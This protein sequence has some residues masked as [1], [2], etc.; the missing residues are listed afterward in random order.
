[1]NML[2]RPDLVAAKLAGDPD[3]AVAAAAAKLDLA[4]LIEGDEPIGGVYR[5]IPTVATHVVIANAAVR[6]DAADSAPSSAD[7]VPGTRVAIVDTK[8]DWTL[9]ARD[10]KRLGYVST[11]ALAPL[12]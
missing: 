4:A 9:I 11:T 8:G 7:I 3:G 12:Q 2:K 10:G 5:P 6:E 1:M